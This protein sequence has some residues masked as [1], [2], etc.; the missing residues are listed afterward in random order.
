MTPSPGKKPASAPE[1]R[2]GARRRCFVTR[3]EADRAA[4]IRFVLDPEGR[5]VPDVAGRLPGRGLWLS[6][7]RDVVNTAVGKGLFAKGFRKAA[8][9]APDLADEV[10]RLLARRCLDC[11]GLA[12][13]AGAVFVGA[14]KVRAALAA[15]QVGALAIAADAA[16][17]GRRRMI[18]RAGGKAGTG[19][20]GGAARSGATEDGAGKDGAPDECGGSAVPVIEMFSAAEL[21]AALGR[22][23]AVHVALRKGRLAARFVA[24]ARR[25]GGFRPTGGG[26][27]AGPPEGKEC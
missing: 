24:E 8:A 15:G 14:E 19:A 11:L 13:R 25:L 22:D 1:A 17:D 10:E 23:H 9:A 4:L 21:G 12:R 2:G 18:A 7:T 5:V 20:E 26:H 3:R 27:G 6:A 16:P